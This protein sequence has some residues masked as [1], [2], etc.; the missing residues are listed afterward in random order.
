MYS[1]WKPVWV[2]L[3]WCTMCTITKHRNDNHFHPEFVAIQVRRFV[4]TIVFIIITSAITNS[5]VDIVTDKQLWTWKSSWNRYKQIRFMLKM[6]KL[7][8]YLYQ[9]WHLVRWTLKL[10]HK[11]FSS[12]KVWHFHC[13]CTDNTSQRKLWKNTLDVHYLLIQNPHM[14]RQFFTSL[15]RVKRSTDCGWQCVLW[16]FR[17]DKLPVCALHILTFWQWTWQRQAATVSWK[18]ILF[19]EGMLPHSALVNRNSGI[20][21]YKLMIVLMETTTT[22]NRKILHFQHLLWCCDFTPRTFWQPQN[23]LQRGFNQ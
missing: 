18:L 1:E 19:S 2:F 5:I 20:H 9:V 21:M 4:I 23:N 17:D 15:N 16:L 13:S 22:V 7:Q 3:G 12:P 11:K 14:R 10:V 6:I 8:L